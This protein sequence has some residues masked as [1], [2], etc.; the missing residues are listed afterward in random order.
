MSHIFIVFKHSGEWVFMSKASEV[1]EQ[2][3]LFIFRRG[4]VD[5]RLPLLHEAQQ[6]Q[7]VVSLKD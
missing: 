6:L 3:L 7:L 4:E 2:L 1:V 5:P